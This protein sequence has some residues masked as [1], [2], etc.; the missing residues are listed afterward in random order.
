M[1]AKQQAKKVA[2]VTGAG[3]GI[4]RCTALALAGAGF[5]VVAADINLRDAEDTC[6]QIDERGGVSASLGVDVT[7]DE[8]CRELVAATMRTYDR[9]DV[10]VNNAGIAGYPLLTE[11]YGI[12]QWLRVMDV[13]LNGVFRCLQHEINAMK[14]NGGGSIV[15]TA[16]VMG[17][18]G[19]IGGS[20]YG[21]AKH[22]VV[23]LTKSA[24][25][26]CGR[27][28]IRINAV[29]PGYIETPMTRGADA[30]FPEGMLERDLSR[31]AMRRFGKPEEIAQ[32]IAW[33]CS[34]NASYITG[35]ILPVDAGI[36]AGF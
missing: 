11:N 24:A 12:D 35:A 13:N 20:A 7:S 31:F 17:I 25:L 4:G 3:S 10:A 33:L 14:I 2:I 36:S 32:T 22:G 9:V 19:A 6:G 18:R 29:C 26:E 23:G 15:N 30:I 21:A 5:I 8:D 1:N 34:E 28:G 27:H 16:S